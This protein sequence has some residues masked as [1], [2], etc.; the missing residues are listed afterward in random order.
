MAH[1]IAPVLCPSPHMHCTMDECRL[2]ATGVGAVGGHA[3]CVPLLPLQSKQ[4]VCDLK[5]NGSVKDIAFTADSRHMYSV[6]SELILTPVHARV[7][8]TV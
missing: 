7:G 2:V 4:W 3:R 8:H 5:M 1:T 6:G